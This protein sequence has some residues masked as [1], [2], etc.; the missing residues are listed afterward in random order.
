MRITWDRVATTEIKGSNVFVKGEQVHC[1]DQYMTLDKISRH[2]DIPISK[3]FSWTSGMYK[4][5]DVVQAQIQDVYE[6]NV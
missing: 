6:K 2:C 3:L 1:E 4:P 5:G